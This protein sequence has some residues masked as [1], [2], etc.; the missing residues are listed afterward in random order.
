M[1]ELPPLP[2][3]C[4]AL[5]HLRGTPTKSPRKGR[6]GASAE[7]GVAKP[8]RLFTSARISMKRNKM[9]AE[10]EGSSSAVASTSKTA[11]STVGGKNSSV[12][13]PLTGSA[14]RRGR[15]PLAVRRLQ[16]DAS[17]S[18]AATVVDGDEVEDVQRPVEQEVDV[19][20][21]AK[22]R[23]AVTK[24]I[25]ERKRK[26][27][28]EF[29]HPRK[30]PREHASTL[31]ILSCL[32]QQRQL[33]EK[34][35]RKEENP[36]ASEGEDVSSRNSETASERRDSNCFER[37]DDLEE[38]DGE[39]GM[40]ATEGGDESGAATRKLVG[41]STG[42]EEKRT[43]TEEEDGGS[44]EVMAATTTDGGDTTETE[45]GAPG[46]SRLKRRSSAKETLIT[47]SRVTSPSILRATN[48]TT[49]TISEEM[50]IP[51]TP[52][53]NT[54]KRSNSAMSSGKKKRRKHQWRARDSI[55][56]Q[57]LNKE[58]E[59]L[60]A[61]PLNASAESI[62]SK[63]LDKSDEFLLPFLECPDFAELVVSVDQAD[64]K[65]GY[66]R[67][68]F[69]PRRTTK[70]PGTV[71]NSILQLDYQLR[72]T[73]KRKN[74]TG[75]PT[76]KRRTSAV[77]GGGA[78][79]V[80]RVGDS[81]SRSVSCDVKGALAQ[82]VL[83]KEAGG[84][85][86]GEGDAEDEE[87][88]SN[89]RAKLT[90][91]T[92]S[93]ASDGEVEL[94]D[95]LQRSP[96][97]RKLLSPHWKRSSGSELMPSPVAHTQATMVLRGTSTSP[98]VLEQRCGS[99][100]QSPMKQRSRGIRSPI[101]DLLMECDSPQSVSSVSVI[102]SDDPDGN[103]LSSDN[104]TQSP[105]GGGG[106]SRLWKQTTLGRFF[107]RRRS[108]A[109]LA[110][111]EEKEKENIVTDENSQE[112][113]EELVV[114]DADGEEEEEGE[115]DEEEVVVGGGEEADA[116]DEMEVV[117]EDEDE[118]IEQEVVVERVEKLVA[119]AKGGGRRR[120]ESKLKNGINLNPIISIKKL[121]TE[122]VNAVV[123]E[124]AAA[125]ATVVTPVKSRRVSRPSARAT[126]S[127][128]SKRRKRKMV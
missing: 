95:P 13:V 62:D 110:A 39:T 71:G 37:D 19:D 78:G 47:A 28:L 100:R 40:T 56:A 85:V 86:T 43:E 11:A 26:L 88:C 36:S 117:A 50:R 92:E 4:C 122:C 105:S 55:N 74:R 119:K 75:W 94:E 116:T 125:A 31:A 52:P 5:S 76:N 106:M 84:A 99:G 8:T 3:N 77:A 54:L 81:K 34:N 20:L 22:Q 79:G 24:N 7:A 63:L 96:I 123:A 112:D 70:A 91:V 103:P 29:E 128:R 102:V 12:V 118:G 98:N 93:M 30:S 80:K 90:I 59:S 49:P 35:R 109:I 72:S 41:K 127:I 23:A 124:V 60:L 115:N 15:P 114:A 45:Q 44:S 126:A 120:S 32:L 89:K 53:P 58:I 121:S 65:Q 61:D 107:N 25:V 14:R 66:V 64:Y 82:T 1:G 38:L 97:L 18:V 83:E 46:S 17:T 113:D 68:S 10:M 16:G 104:R 67:K 108:S 51:K 6:A 21:S 27:L 9:L 2:E 73:K 111:A 33:N 69:A 101:A 48:N 57:E 87:N 42:V